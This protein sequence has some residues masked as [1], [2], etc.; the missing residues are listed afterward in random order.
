MNFSPELWF[1]DM[2]NLEEVSGGRPSWF[3]DS[4]DNL[5]LL[6]EELVEALRDETARRAARSQPPLS[7]G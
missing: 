5:A 1:E 4:E 2:E 3:R 6:D 7:E